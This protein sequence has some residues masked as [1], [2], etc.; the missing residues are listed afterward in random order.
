MNSLC[1]GC[2]AVE[3]PRSR[4]YCAMCYADG[5]ADKCKEQTVLH[6]TAA[7]MKQLAEEAVAYNTGIDALIDP[8]PDDQ[9]QHFPK[10][11]ID[12]ANPSIQELAKRTLARRGLLGFIQRFKPKYNAGWVHK[13]ICRRLERF[14]KDV[15]D[16]KEPRLML[17]LPVRHGKSEIASRHFAPWVLGKHPDWEIIAASGAQSLA[18]SFSRYIRDLI[19]DPSYQA[20]FPQMSLDPSSQSVENWNSTSGGGYLAA[21]IGTMITGRGCH[22]LVIDDPVKDAEAADSQGQ[23]DAT[24][25]WYMSTAYT[26]LAPGGGVLVVMTTW[27]DDDFAGRIQQSM[28]TGDGDMFEI[29]KYPAINDIGDEYILPDDTMAQLPEGSFIPEGALLTR[30]KGTALHPERYTADSL[31]RRKASYYA[32]GQQRWWSALFQQNPAPDEGAYFTK[33]MFKIYTDEPRLPGK[34]LYQAWDFAI[35]TNTASD[36]TVG[37]TIMQDEKDDLYVL[38]VYRFRSGDGI[39]IVDTIV[40]YARLWNVGLIGVEDGQIWKSLASTF[41][42]TCENKQYYPAYEVLKP[43]TDKM[44][45]AQPLRGRMQAGKLYWPAR[46][47]WFDELRTEFLRFPAGKHDDQIDSVAWCVRLML[48]KSAPQLPQAK[49]LESWRDKIK[50]HLDVGGHMSA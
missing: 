45:R 44:V 10:V 19:R 17:M 41:A 28:A 36:W 24:W 2:G 26:R 49:R 40:E 42:K 35:T 25:E 47:A 13:D 23:R 32:L 34:N 39:D 27:N 9:A 43:L 4:D 11:E 46:A 37:C 8:N 5:T 22:I 21:G 30:L 6:I 29:V 20:V 16:F 33:S 1:P 48:T 38:D 14:M 31:L 3:I 18:M 15:E 50:K 12:A 7:E